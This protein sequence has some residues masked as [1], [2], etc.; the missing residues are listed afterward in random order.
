MDRGGAVPPGYWLEV[1]I[2][3]A[4]TD[5]TAVARGSH[6]VRT[7]PH[8]VATAEL[9]HRF[10]EWVRRIAKDGQPLTPPAQAEA[11]H[12]ALFQKGLQEVV[13]KLQGAAGGEPLLLRLMP[14]SRE[15]EGIPW[16]ALCQ[17]GKEMKFLGTSEELCLVRGVHST[18]LWSPREVKGAVKLL[19]ISPLDPEAPGLLKAEIQPAIDEGRIE[20]LEPLVGPRARRDHVLDRLQR[21]PV[22]HI[23]HFIGHGT[24]SPALQFADEEDGRDGLASDE[25]GRSKKSWLK[26]A[27]LAQELEPAFRGDLRLVV[28]ESCAG[29]QPGELTS[30]ASRLAE[31]GADAVV[32]HLWP[33]NADVARE[34]S[35]VFYRTL[36]EDTPQRGDVA[37]SL[38]AA[39]RRV[40][41]RFNES[42][43]AF[44][45][46]LYLRNQSSALFDFRNRTVTPPRGPGP[47]GGGPPVDDPGVRGLL[48]MLGRP[49]SLVLGDRWSASRAGFR[50]RLHGKLKGPWAAPQ[51]LSMSTLAQRYALHAG[52]ETLDS[53]FQKEFRGAAPALPLVEAVARHLPPGVHVSLLRTPVLEQALAAQRPTLTFYVIQPQPS[54]PYGREAPLIRRRQPG[55]DWEELDK[56][57]EEF[58]PERETTLVRLYRG[59]LPDNVFKTPLLTEDD[60]LLD[61]RDLESVLT[62]DLSDILLGTLRSRPALL[63][64]MSLLTWHHRMLLRGLF[65]SKPLPDNSQVVLEVNE[66][67]VDSWKRG[68]G[69]PSDRSVQVVQAIPEGLASVI[70]AIPPGGMP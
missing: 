50:E 22:P 37:R 32:A 26:V 46:V 69:L 29:A 40:L 19:V 21:A 23:L 17:P 36:I 5:I 33:V 63:L 43:E 14:K 16:E 30:A 2:T 20:W 66:P 68:R 47:S 18:R 45:P 27:L 12:A 6:E 13:H 56:L 34:C 10:G 67:E 41:A 55:G 15:L 64:G 3:Q 31:S 9:V 52:P 35:A 7:V 51:G 48:D 59:F 38:H 44:S 65:D 54:G 28:L 60:Y 4:G 11:L 58:N 49:F 53:L 39:R 25:E 62:P 61:M 57:P 70:D 24:S 1:D 42:A 8:S